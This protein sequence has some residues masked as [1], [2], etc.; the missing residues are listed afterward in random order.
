MFSIEDAAWNCVSCE[1][2]SA[3]KMKVKGLITK[4]LPVLKVDG[5]FVRNPQV[6]TDRYVDDGEI[7]YGEMKT[8]EAFAEGKEP[9]ARK[10]ILQAITNT[11]P[12]AQLMD[13]QIS[14]LRQWAMGRAREAGAGE[15]TTRRRNGRR[16]QAQAN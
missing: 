7:A 8:G 5:S 14:A 11:V 15:P 1:M 2:W 9:S 10:H 13:G 3:Y 16:V 4:V 12:L 6:I